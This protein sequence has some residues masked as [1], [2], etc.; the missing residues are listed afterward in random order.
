MPIIWINIPT[1][2]SP[3]VH[4]RRS[5]PKELKQYVRDVVENSYPARARNKPKLH[6]L[7]F[8]ADAEY[9]CALVE[10]LDDYVALKAVTRVLGAEYATKLLTPD[11][12]ERAI[13]RASNL[14]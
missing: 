3:G 10:G 5:K 13:K 11:G 12:A 14:G 4:E 1:G 6:E 2:S 8:Q 9:A 7:Y